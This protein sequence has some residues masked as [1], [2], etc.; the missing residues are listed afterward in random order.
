MADLRVLIVEDDPL[1][2]ELTVRELQKSGY[3]PEW[4]QVD[5]QAEFM[6]RLAQD[7]P[8]VIISD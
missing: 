5:T 7:P 3:D 8:D 4:Q 1:D 6:N 2:A